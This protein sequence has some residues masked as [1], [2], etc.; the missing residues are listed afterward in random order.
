MTDIFLTRDDRPRTGFDPVFRV[1][2]AIGAPLAASYGRFRQRQALADLDDRLLADL[3]LTRNDVA[4]ECAK[5][6]WPV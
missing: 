3:G 6:W 4:H 1:V 5:S 2:R